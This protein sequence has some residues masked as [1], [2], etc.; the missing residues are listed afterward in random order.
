MRKPFARLFLLA[1]MTVLAA[2]CGR[3]L[4]ACS[5]P[6]FRYA[7]ERWPADAYEAVVFHRGALSPEQQA[8]VERLEKA[9]EDPNVSANLVVRKVDLDGEIDKGMTALWKTEKAAKIP[10]VVLLYPQRGGFRFGFT[11]VPPAARRVVSGPLEAKT[12]GLFLDSP[13]RRKIASAL[14]EGQSAVWAFLESGEPQ[15]DR[16][17]FETLEKHLKK[18]EKELQLPEILDSDLREVGIDREDVDSIQVKF[19]ALR[20]SR[21]DATESAF[22]RMLLGVEE[23]LIPAEGEP[24]QPMAFPVFGRGRA[25]Y[26]LLGA[27]INE[28]TIREACAFL[29]GPCS[30]Q[31]KEQNPG[32]DLLMSVNWNELVT[33]ESVM[34]Q[35]LPE[36]SGFESFID[37][38]PSA[39]NGEASANVVEALSTG[40]V[41]V[42]ER[43]GG[44]AGETGA[45]V[46]EGGETRPPPDAAV[47]PGNLLRNSLLA[48]LL[49]LIALAVLTLLVR[50]KTV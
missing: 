5:V 46:P 10:W 37:L 25:L 27:G 30:C 12:C 16:A 50:G 28:D 21:K 7:L 6:V 17:A 48:L 36:L 11:G 24:L 38:K 43:K 40:A 49:G 13:L 32:V 2:A 45:A 20:V 34:D 33:T 22:I 39:G 19:S 23:D 9:S 18:M 47:A 44:P 29:V 3:P 42:E 26:A 41:S 31:V 14:V 35:L 1:S 15:K 8:T 4:L